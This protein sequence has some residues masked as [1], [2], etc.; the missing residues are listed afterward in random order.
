M[1][2][3]PKLPVHTSSLPLTLPPASTTHTTGPR[4]LSTTTTTALTT[5]LVSSNGIER[6]EASLRH[7]LATSGFSAALRT[8]VVT[9]LRSGESASFQD[10]MKKVLAAVTAATSEGGGGKLVGGGLGGGM[11]EG[12][13]GLG[14]PE[15][16]IRETL[17]VVT[18]EIREVCDVR[19]NDTDD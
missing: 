14:V 16:A 15:V 4:P 3:S 1:P 6:I 18:R 7:E 17:R 2:P 11:L 19:V 9:Q 12:E 13:K 10:V 5:A 8:Y